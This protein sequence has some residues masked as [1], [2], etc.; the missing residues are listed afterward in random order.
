[1]K[2]QKATEAFC[3]FAMLEHSNFG[4]IVALVSSHLEVQMGDV[5]CVYAVRAAVV[6]QGQKKA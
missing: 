1:M 2:Q 4:G 3:D 6:S 5:W